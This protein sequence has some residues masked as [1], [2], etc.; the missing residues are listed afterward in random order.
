MTATAVLEMVCPVCRSALD[1]TTSSWRCEGCDRG[2][3]VVAGIPD[4]RVEPDP[5]IGLDEDRNKAV[6]VERETRGLGFAAAVRRYWALTPSTPSHLAERFIAHVL[7]AEERSREWLQRTRIAQDSQD[8]E[9]WLDLGTGTADLASAAPPRIH[10]VGLD[11]ALRWLVLARRRLEESGIE[12]TLIC[13][14]GEHLPFRE[15]TFHRVLSLGA[16]EHCRDA[17]AVLREARRV[18]APRGRIA[19]RTANRFTALPEPHVGLW[20]VGWLPRRWADPYVRVRSGQGYRH[21]RPLGPLELRR[22]MIE[23][24]FREVR[25]EAAAP[26]EAETRRMGGFGRRAASTYDRL[27]GWPLLGPALR[28]VSPLLAAEGSAP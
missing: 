8:G 17:S 10:A 26:L 12:A 15:G 4:L 24:G 11:V 19:L 14:N 21:H 25:V 3:P 1:R 9:W 23:A 18:T 16:L 20:G 5:W 13:G 22:A 7:A 6:R 2:F 28:T 27:R